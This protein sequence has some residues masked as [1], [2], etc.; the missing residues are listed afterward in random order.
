MTEIVASIGKLKNNMTS[1]PDCIPAFL[2]KDCSVI[3]APILTFIF[4]LA[5]S[6]S[7]FPGVWG[8]AR[9]CPILKSGSASSV[10]NYRPVS[11]L[12]NFAK[13]FEM[14]VY[15]RLFAEVKQAI[16]PFQH[17]FFVGRSTVSNLICFSQ[18]VSEILDN[19]GQVD[20]V[21]TDFSK[22]FDRIG[23]DLILE[24]LEGFDFGVSLL[25]FFA[26]YMDNRRYYVKYNGYRS[27]YYLGTSGV[28]Q[29]SNLGPLL[30]LLFIND[31]VNVVS[32]K[33]LIYADDIKLFS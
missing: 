16:S 17:G 5:L 11:I 10:S 15:T 14:A 30:F 7:S 18:Y 6:T 24:K 13:I 4:N 33:I 29:G 19:R 25:K 2:V 12:N 28:P 1:G 31:V 8:V 20:V 23:H 22:A 9:V 27:P 3:F 26:S 21:Y 32:C